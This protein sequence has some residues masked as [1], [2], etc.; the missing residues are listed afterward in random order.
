MTV[1]LLPTPLTLGRPLQTIDRGP[2][3]GRRIRLMVVDPHPLVRWFLNEIADGRADMT[4][5]GIAAT[6]GEA[7]A[8]AFG[9]C[10]DVATIECSDPGGA[11]WA[12]AARLRDTYPMMGIVILSTDVSDE[13]MHRAFEVG[14]SAFASKCAPI[15]DVVAAIRHAAEEP[16]S[17]AAA[18][19][20][21]ARH[22]RPGTGLRS[23]DAPGRHAARVG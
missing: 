17:F 14:A 21:A 15:E 10:P 1:E 22:R 2:A 6:E 4:G 20:A 19:L 3:L 9:V 12:T 5:V 8:I 11:G 23:A 16:T 7:M 13:T 18:G